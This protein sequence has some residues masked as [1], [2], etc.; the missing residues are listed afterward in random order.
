MGRKKRQENLFLI[1]HHAIIRY[2]IR[3][4]EEEE[5]KRITYN[6]SAHGDQLL[7]RHVRMIEDNDNRAH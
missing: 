3:I 1:L 4:E 6:G 5:E 7:T 2:F